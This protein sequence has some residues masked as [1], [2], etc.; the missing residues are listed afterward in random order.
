MNTHSLT[1]AQL[2]A[3]F[4]ARDE[5]AAVIADFV[6]N[7]QRKRSSFDCY[8]HGYVVTHSLGYTVN[9]HFPN[10][11]K[12][13]GREVKDRSEKLSDQLRAVIAKHNLPRDLR[14]DVKHKGFEYGEAE[15]WVE[16][17]LSAQA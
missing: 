8:A 3:A 14:F 5:M 9:T 16:L 4:K 11:D 7:G 12:L 13:T 2:I 6:Y 15:T 10:D 1:Q 17:T